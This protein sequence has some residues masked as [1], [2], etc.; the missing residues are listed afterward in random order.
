MKYDTV[1]VIICVV[2][3]TAPTLCYCIYSSHFKF[4]CFNNRENN[5]VVFT[6]ANL[7]TTPI[8]FAADSKSL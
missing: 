2:P 8:D 5:L 3:I 7:K 6:N 4:Y 1:F